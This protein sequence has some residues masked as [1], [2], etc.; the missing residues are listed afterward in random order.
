MYAC[1]LRWSTSFSSKDRLEKEAARGCSP[2]KDLAPLPVGETDMRHLQGQNIAIPRPVEEHCETHTHMMDCM[3]SFHLTFRC[4]RWK[5]TELFSIKTSQAVNPGSGQQWR[6]ERYTMCKH[7]VQTWRAHQVNFSW[8]WRLCYGYVFLFFMARWSCQD[9]SQTQSQ[10]WG[11]ECFIT[12][13]CLCSLSLAVNLCYCLLASE[14]FIDFNEQVKICL[15]V[16]KMNIA[17]LP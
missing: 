11:N 5:P 12:N 2:L 17:Y 16:M 6:N 13:F 10:S 15:W 9:V 7:D 8:A 3:E 14:H 4:N 1:S